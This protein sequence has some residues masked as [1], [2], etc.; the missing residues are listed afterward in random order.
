MGR[1]RNRTDKEWGRRDE[2]RR[3]N[4][5]NRKLKSIKTWQIVSMIWWSKYPSTTIAGP[6]TVS[7]SIAR[8]RSYMAREATMMLYDPEGW[9]ELEKVKRDDLQGGL[10]SCSNGKVSEGR[11]EVRTQQE[12][13]KKRQQKHEQ[14]FLNRSQAASLSYQSLACLLRHFS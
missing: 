4:M 13:A 12:K 2:K 11:W 10:L 7:P 1:I 6:R 8:L 3:R 5:M 14:F 9:G